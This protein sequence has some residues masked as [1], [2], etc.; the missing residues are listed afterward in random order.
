MRPARFVMACDFIRAGGIARQVRVSVREAGACGGR[1][2]G[3]DVF[4]F[5]QWKDLWYGS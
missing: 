5:L 2:F 3:K 4:F 1:G